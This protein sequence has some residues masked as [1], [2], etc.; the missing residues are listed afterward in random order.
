MCLDKFPFHPKMFQIFIE[1][2]HF[3]LVNV[4]CQANVANVAHQANVVGKQ[5]NRRWDSGWLSIFSLQQWSTL[6]IQFCWR[7]FFPVDLLLYDDK[8]VIEGLVK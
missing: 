2:V 8:G 3:R 6:N 1:K 5:N 7:S 4:V